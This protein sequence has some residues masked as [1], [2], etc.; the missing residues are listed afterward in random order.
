LAPEI[1]RSTDTGLIK[2][3]RDLNRIRFCLLEVFVMPHKRVELPTKVV[4]E[5]VRD[6]QAFL[7]ESNALKRDEI[8]ARQCLALQSFQGSQDK[9]LCLSDVK[10]MFLKIK[11]G[12]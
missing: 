2:K 1:R 3:R 7:K 5:F 8:V 9:K 6:R 11:H 4:M 12:S 10:A